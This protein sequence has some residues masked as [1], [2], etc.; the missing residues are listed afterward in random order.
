MSTFSE[1][2]SAISVNPFGEF[3][4][5][6]NQD[7]MKEND[8][9]TN[10]LSLQSIGEVETEEFGPTYFQIDTR[11]GVD[12]EGTDISSVHTGDGRRD[13]PVDDVRTGSME[14]K[15]SGLNSQEKH[16]SVTDRLHSE[17]TQSVRSKQN[18]PVNK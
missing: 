2:E 12:S 8:F 6:E 18:P 14:Q 3:A 13:S 1:I 7:S 11:R 5:A 16:I 4:L 10:A 15:R 9:L 17:T